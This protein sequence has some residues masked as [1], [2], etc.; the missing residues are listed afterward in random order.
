MGDNDE[1][2]KSVSSGGPDQYAPLSPQHPRV[3]AAGLAFEKWWTKYQPVA[4]LADT[5]LDELPPGVHPRAI[6][7]E[8]DQESEELFFAGLTVGETRDRITGSP[9]FPA[10]TEI[11]TS[12]LLR[13]SDRI[14][15]VP[16]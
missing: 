4:Y 10:P 8:F 2:G 11:W 6:W 1:A 13:K 7:T 12:G 14:A 16:I 3:I 9:Q 15:R 5:V